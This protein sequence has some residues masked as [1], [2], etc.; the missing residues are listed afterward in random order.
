MRLRIASRSNESN[1]QRTSHPVLSGLLK[2]VIMA[3][4]IRPIDDRIEAPETIKNTA[5]SIDQK[6]I[7]S[8]PNNTPKCFKVEYSDN[9]R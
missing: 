3:G 7:V 2:T 9:K 1:T 4:I 6:R 8:S 5:T